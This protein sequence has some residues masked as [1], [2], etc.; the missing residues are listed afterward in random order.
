M[1]WIE[2]LREQVDELRD[3]IQETPVSM[4][5]RL[6]ALGKDRSGSGDGFVDMGQ[7]LDEDFIDPS[8]AATHENE[9]D[10]YKMRQTAARTV[11]E[12]SDRVLQR[13]DKRWEIIGTLADKIDRT[14][15]L[16][17]AMDLQNRLLVEN[18]KLQL[19]IL[20]LAALSTEAENLRNY[21]GTGN[22]RNG[23]DY[24]PRDGRER[25]EQGPQLSEFMRKQLREANINPNG[26]FNVNAVK[27]SI[28]GG[29]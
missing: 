15:N 29:W 25:R 22:G 7:I 12:K 11:I 18:L 8:A 20:T 5:E 26:D 10:R 2:R 27:R 1:S 3:E 17:D 28:N 24:T 13:L 21:R 9:S 14:Q 16:K 4:G 6:D 23:S 19:E